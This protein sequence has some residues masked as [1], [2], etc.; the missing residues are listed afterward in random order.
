MLKPFLCVFEFHP[1]KFLFVPLK[2]TGEAGHQNSN[3]IIAF[4]AGTLLFGV[5]KKTYMQKGKKIATVKAF[6]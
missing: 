1:K 6:L 5:G 4:Q 3:L 2:I